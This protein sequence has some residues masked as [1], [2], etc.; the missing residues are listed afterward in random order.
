MLLG[1]LEDQGW[2]ICLP[3]G[4][5]ELQSWDSNLFAN[6]WKVNRVYPMEVRVI[7]PQSV[8]AAW[9]NGDEQVKL[10]HDKLVKHLECCAGCYGK[11]GKW[12]GGNPDDLAS[13]PRSLIVQD[14]SGVSTKQCKWDGLYGPTC[15]D[16]WP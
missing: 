10:T 2:D 6:I 5:M 13:V 8:L 7:P 4:R 11:R 12:N 3:K 1:K 16:P 15:K 14:C 9:T